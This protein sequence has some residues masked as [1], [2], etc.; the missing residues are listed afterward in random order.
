MKIKFHVDKA[1]VVISNKFS[2][3]LKIL[4]FMQKPKFPEAANNCV[5]V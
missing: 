5:F 3:E 1:V 2:N 4:S